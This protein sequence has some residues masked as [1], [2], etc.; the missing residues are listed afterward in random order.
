MFSKVVPFPMAKCEERK[1][2]PTISK[3]LAQNC[4]LY[5]TE[6]YETMLKQPIRIEYLIK[7]EPRGTLAGRQERKEGSNRRGRCLYK[8]AWGI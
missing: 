4:V 2:L 3:S 7:H 1:S 8:L 5:R 6:I